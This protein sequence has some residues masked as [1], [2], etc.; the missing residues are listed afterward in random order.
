MLFR[1]SDLLPGA[2]VVDYQPDDYLL[3]PGYYGRRRV[4][5]PGGY[6]DIVQSRTASPFTIVSGYWSTHV[7]NALSAD[8]FWSAYPAHTLQLKGIYNHT[9]KGGCYTS[10]VEKHLERGFLISAASELEQDVDLT[11]TC[12]AYVGCPQRDRVWGDSLTLKLP[13][14]HDSVPA[15]MMSMEGTFMAMWRLGAPGCGGPRCLLETE[16]HS[17]CVRWML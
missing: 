14:T 6:I 12:D 11:E 13:L 4:R 2:T 16:Y 15:L 1:S 3:L 5:T 7:M 17:T 8:A 10:A 9:P